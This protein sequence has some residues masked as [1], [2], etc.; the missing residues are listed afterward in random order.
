MDFW[1]PLIK[2]REVEFPVVQLRDVKS[3]MKMDQNT[4][5]II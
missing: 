2:A 1:R 5:D 4:S 3:S